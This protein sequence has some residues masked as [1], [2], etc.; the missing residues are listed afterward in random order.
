[1]SSD[2]SAIALFEKKISHIF[3][4]SDPGWKSSLVQVQN[5]LNNRV[6]FGFR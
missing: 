4:T 6:F 1:M 5:V 3:N 2:A